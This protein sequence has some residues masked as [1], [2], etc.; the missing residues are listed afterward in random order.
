M[1]DVIVRLDERW[2]R[3]VY[4]AKVEYSPTD[5]EAIHQLFVDWHRPCAKVLDQLEAF[6]RAGLDV[7][8]ARE[9]RARCREAEGILTPDARFFA[10]DALVR[11]R[12]EALDQHKEGQTLEYGP[13]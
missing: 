3:D 12:D 6:E 1:F 5:A 9:F 11:L 8:W 7:K 4:R 2:R 13:T 10:D